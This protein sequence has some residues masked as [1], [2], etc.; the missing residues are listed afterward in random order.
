MCSWVCALENRFLCVWINIIQLSILQQGFRGT[1]VFRKTC[2]G[3]TWVLRVPRFFR[4]MIFCF[5]MLMRHYE[6]FRQPCCIQI[7]SGPVSCTGCW[8]QLRA[9]KESDSCCFACSLLCKKE[10]YCCITVIRC[11]RCTVHSRDRSPLEICSLFKS[12]TLGTLFQ[13]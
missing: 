8:V 2:S 7:P 1:L 10:R 5:S 3:I 11:C 9:E 12:I 6:N 4:E 13:I